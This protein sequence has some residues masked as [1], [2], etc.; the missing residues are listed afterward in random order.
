[1]MEVVK[2]DIV[3]TD[4]INFNFGIIY[5]DLISSRTNS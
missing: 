5:K 2:I 4:V 3:D 1:M